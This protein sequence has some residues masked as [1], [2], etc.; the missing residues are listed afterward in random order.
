M[1]NDFYKEW[2]KTFLKWKI[3][4]HHP[5]YSKPNEVVFC[6]QICHDKIHKGKLKVD[7]NRI[8][9]LGSF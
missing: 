1:A 6:C 7:S 2:D 3:V 4:A 9:D 8:V 5:D